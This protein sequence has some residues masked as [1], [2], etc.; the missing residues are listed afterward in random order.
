M[1][2]LSSPSHGLDVMDVAGPVNDQRF[3]FKPKNTLR[4]V[5]RDEERGL[6]RDGGVWTGVRDRE[7][8]RDRERD[9]ERV[10]GHSC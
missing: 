6:R 5:S 7:K 10:R 1:V 3:L 4:F 8:V 9:R 2:F